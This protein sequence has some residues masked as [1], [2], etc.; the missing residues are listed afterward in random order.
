MSN[1]SA[2]VRVRVTGSR[3]YPERPMVGVG[4]VVISGGRA[5]LVRR[6]RA[7]LEGQWSIPGGMLEVGE[8]L[9]EGVRRELLEETGV[10]VRVGELIEVFERITPDSDAKTRYH[11]VVL[12]YL[13]EAVCGEARAGSDVVDV[14]WAAPSELATFSISETATR[15]IMKAFEMA[16]RTRKAPA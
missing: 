11:F 9:L 13:C 10:E 7:P 2:G 6:G 16:S 5:L 14:A 12:D 15:V 8:T 1:Y 3:E 4:G